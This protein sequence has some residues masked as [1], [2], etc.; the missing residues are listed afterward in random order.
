VN[1]IR[2]KKAV[3]TWTPSL[4]GFARYS[5]RNSRMLRAGYVVRVLAEAI[6][7]RMLVEAIGREGKPVRFTVKIKNLACMA[8]GLFD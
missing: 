6:G 8:P 4:N 5:G 1:G 2:N 7:E 3:D